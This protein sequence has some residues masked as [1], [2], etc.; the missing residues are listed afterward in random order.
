MDDLDKYLALPPEANLD[1]DVLAWWKARDH[2]LPADAASGRPKAR[3]RQ[4]MAR[5]FLGPCDA[6]ASIAAWKLP[7]VLW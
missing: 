6:A 5:Q 2:A 3:A 4:E 7:L 1:L